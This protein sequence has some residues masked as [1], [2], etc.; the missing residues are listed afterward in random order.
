VAA[1]QVLAELGPG[2]PEL[3]GVERIVRDGNG[4]DRQRDMH[5]RGGMPALLR[6]LAEATTWPLRG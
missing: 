1:S 6:Y 5:G 4:A 2:D 3:E